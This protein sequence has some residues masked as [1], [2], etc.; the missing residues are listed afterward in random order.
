MRHKAINGGTIGRARLGYLNV[1]RE[2]DGHLINTIDVDPERGPL[3]RRGFEL[4]ATGDYTRNRLADTMEDLGLTARP[5][6]RHPQRRPVTL[7]KWHR[8]LSDLYYAGYIV[9][10]GER[11]PGRHE[12]LVSHELFSTV[13]NVLAARS[14]GGTRDRV[15]HHYL[16]GLLA[17]DRCR[18]RGRS[19]RLVFVEANGR[20]GQY[21]YFTCVARLDSGRCDLP[22]L[23]AWQVEDAV[24]D[25]FATIEPPL[26]WTAA[27]EREVTD[28]LDDEQRTVHELRAAA[29]KKLTKLDA[30]EEHLLD[31]L[32]DSSL[33]VDKIRARL[34]KLQLE[35]AT[36]HL[37]ARTGPRR[38]DIAAAIFH[39]FYFNEHGGQTESDLQPEF[40]HLVGAF[41]AFPSALGVPDMQKGPDV[42]VEAPE[43]SDSL[44]LS[45][46]L[47]V[48]VPIGPLWCARGD[49]RAVAFGIVGPSYRRFSLQ[50]QWFCFKSFWVRDE[51]NGYVTTHVGTA[52]PRNI[53]AKWLTWP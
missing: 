46:L 18:Q 32:A 49:L 16:R 29:T 22:Y 3:I 47:F 45:D 24:I 35:R 12:A 38:R 13:Q 39:R 5:S 25:H 34:R 6:P 27:I 10:D 20:G 17:C 52:N 53:V 14:K 9:H 26:G 31:L 11:Y 48:E 1:R 2:I 8:M 51:R 40:E 42:A 44:T 7:K 50:Y 37:P 33:P 19:S 28:L 41:H 15:H 23:P 43:S 4:Y 21:Q 36:T 30:Q